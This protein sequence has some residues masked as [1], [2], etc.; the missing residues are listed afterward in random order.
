MEHHQSYKILSHLYHFKH[1]NNNLV[2]V[3][4]TKSMVT[5]PIMIQ[6][7]VTDHYTSEECDGQRLKW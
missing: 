1:D 4:I 2:I 6:V 7:T 3:V 5:A